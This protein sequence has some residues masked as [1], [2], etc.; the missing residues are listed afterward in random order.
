MSSITL[1]LSR[2]RQVIYKMLNKIE[3]LKKI[4]FWFF[5]FIYETNM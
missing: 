2:S 1:G 5:D 3:F 4:S